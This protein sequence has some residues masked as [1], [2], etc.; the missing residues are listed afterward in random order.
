MLGDGFK[1]A[2]TLDGHIDFAVPS[3]GTYQL[4]LGQARL[5]LVALSGAI[6]DVTT[7]CLYD[8]DALL[9]PPHL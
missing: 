2:G 9:E 5:M 4:T 8:R 6:E 1:I 3:H 7:N